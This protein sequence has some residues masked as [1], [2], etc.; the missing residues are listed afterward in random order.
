MCVRSKCTGQGRS[1]K[2]LAATPEL[3]QLSELVD[4]QLAEYREQWKM[5]EACA[6]LADLEQAWEERE[7]DYYT[8]IDQTVADLKEAYRKRCE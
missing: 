8:Q 1:R 5:S 2:K 3:R 7:P 6:K 4:A